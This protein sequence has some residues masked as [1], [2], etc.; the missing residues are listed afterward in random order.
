M[1]I[2]TMNIDQSLTDSPHIRQVDQ[3]SVDPTN[4]VPITVQ[5]TLQDQPI[6]IVTDTYLV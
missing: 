6:I 5:L 1:L 4:I 3:F 2:L